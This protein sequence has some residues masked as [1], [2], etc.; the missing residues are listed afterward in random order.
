MLQM[1]IVVFIATAVLSTAVK[2]SADGAATA[3]ADSCDE[4]LYLTK[5][6]RH[7]QLLANSFES[8]IEEQRRD[9]RK[10][11]IAA[12]A[13]ENKKERC[14]LN[15]LAALTAAELEE[16]E[17]QQGSIRRAA[18]AAIA[19]IE[20]Q[21]KLVARAGQLYRIKTSIA[22]GSVHVRSPGGSHGVKLMLTTTTDDA[23][24]CTKL[25]ADETT[26]IKGKT[27]AI[28]NLVSIK[29][30]DPA[31][32]AKTLPTGYLKATASGSCTGG[33]S[34][35]PDQKAAAAFNSC[36]FGNDDANPAIT[37]N[38]A[39]YTDAMSTVNIFTSG[40]VKT[41]HSDVA[42]A[43]PGATEN[44]H[45]GKLLCE[46]LKH[47][48]TPVKTEISGPAVRTN[49]ELLQAVAACDP[50]YKD[51][52]D[53]T[54]QNKNGEIKKY[55]TE[56]YG[57]NNGDFKN[58]FENIIDKKNVPSKTGATMGTKTIGQVTTDTE[59]Q[60][61][62]NHLELQR[63]SREARAAKPASAPKAVDSKKVEEKCK[64]KPQGEC[65]DED[66]CEFKDGECKAKVAT[67]TGTDEKTNTTGSNSFA[68][69]KAPLWIAVL[70]F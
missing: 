34:E 44:R 14:L 28:D 47:A 24:G 41:C 57:T 3:I 10:F 27:I 63:S 54:D 12:A 21:E 1:L 69:H 31:K 18:T 4:E 49:K 67:A 39:T 33:G 15:G 51:I 46:V 40:S 64:G 25:A 35:A 38:K 60:Q 29:L 6:K 58:I 61:I 30:T 7:I 55:V 22:P 52:A 23:D 53:A 59:A 13:S 17:R 9:K 65:E 68:I 16:N 50:T 56:A 62:L 19:E 45:L 5:L 20:K 42:T 48:T 11:T 66:G 70:L 2:G 37:R 8:T 32:L 26:Q 36:T 43:E